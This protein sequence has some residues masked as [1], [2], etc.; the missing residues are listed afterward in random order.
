MGLT[1]NSISKTIKR[2]SNRFYKYTT[3]ARVRAKLNSND[4]SQ[5]ILFD[6]LRDLLYLSY[7]FGPH[8]VKARVF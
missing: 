8:L 7:T 1:T 2:R 6:T 3:L 4:I 5:I